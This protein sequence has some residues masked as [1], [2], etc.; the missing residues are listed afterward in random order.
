MVRLMLYLSKQMKEAVQ[1]KLGSRG[2]VVLV[3]PVPATVVEEESFPVHDDLHKICEIN[4]WYCTPSKI[5]NCLYAVFNAYCNALHIDEDLINCGMSPQV[6][7]QYREALNGRNLV[8]VMDFQDYTYVSKAW[9]VMMKVIIQMALRLTPRQLIS[10]GSIEESKPQPTLVTERRKSESGS[11]PVSRPSEQ[12]SL[13]QKST[14]AP[15]TS[16]SELDKPTS[17]PT[18]AMASPSEQGTI[19]QSPTPAAVMKSEQ[20]VSNARW[21]AVTVTELPEQVKSNHTLTPAVLMQHDELN[22]NPAP[23]EAMT[24]KTSEKGELVNKLNYNYNNVIIIGSKCMYTQLKLME[25]DLPLHFIDQRVYFNDLNK[26]IIKEYQKN[27][28]HHALWVLLVDLPSLLYTPTLAGPKC[29]EAKCLNPVLYCDLKKSYSFT[30][31]KTGISKIINQARDFISSAKEYLGEGSSIV[32]AP[33]PPDAVVWAGVNSHCS[34]S[35]IHAVREKKLN[36]SFLIGQS[37]LWNVYSTALISEWMAMLEDL[38]LKAEQRALLKKYHSERKLILSF[39]DITQDISKDV[40]ILRHWNELMKDMLQC[41][42]NTEDT[43]GQPVKE[44]STFYGKLNLCL[45]TGNI[46]LLFSDFM[47]LQI[48]KHSFCMKNFQ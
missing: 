45:D 17:I 27:W 38:S 11:L 48:Q 7:M 25:L 31:V 15:L 26:V 3:P 20:D 5:L 33:I 8:P 22:L 37:Q 4:N 30:Q 41:L 29:L 44:A 34:H 47:F 18:P 35:Y 43:K 32:L 12:E 2:V 16:P 24:P 39:I 40:G 42:M 36:I 14:A 13:N 10:Q 9:I 6:I 21:K 1:R 46:Y 19:N 23:K 28:S